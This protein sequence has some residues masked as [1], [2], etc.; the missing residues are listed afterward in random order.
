M[1]HTYEKISANSRWLPYPKNHFA[2]WAV[3]FLI[4]GTIYASPI[5]SS[6]RIPKMGLQQTVTGTVTDQ[7]NV[8]LPGVTIL[9]KGTTSG[10]VSDIDGKYTIDTASDD[11]LAFSY[12]GFRSIEVPV[13]GQSVIDVTLEEDL[14]NLDEV[15]II[16]YGSVKKSDLT[17]SVSS[18][19]DESFNKGA[20][21][22]VEQLIQGRA[23]GVQITQANAQ[24]G[25]AFSIRI[26]GATSITA[27]NEPLFV[28]DGLPS[29]PQNAINPGDIE[30]IEIL[31]DASATAIYGSRGANGVVLITTKQGKAGKI[32]VDY[33]TYA[34][35][36]EVENRLDLLN[37]QEYISFINGIR[38]DQGEDPQFSP[39]DIAAIG[40]GTD[41]QDAIFRSAFVQ[42][43]QFS[44]SGG[45]E[46][47]K[48]YTSLNYFDQ[49]GVVLSSGI[50]RYTGRVNIS[51]TGDKFNF[52]VNLNTSVVVSD[53]VPLGNGINI[54]AGTIGTALQFDPTLAIFDENGD[55]VQSPNLDLNN[56][57]AL[58]ETIEPRSETDRTFGTLFAEYEFFKGFSAKAN[59]G[60][61]RRNIRSDFYA[62]PVTK[63]GQLGNGSASINHAR[64]TSY[65]A[66]LTASYDKTFGEDH[67][68]N[69]LAGI[70][71]QEFNFQGFNAGSQNF[72]TDQFGTDNLGAGDLE[73]Y[74]VGSSR[75]KNQLLSYIGRANYIYKDR[76]LVTATVRADGS[77]RFGED[78][79]YGYFPSVALGWKM[80]NESFLQNATAISNLKLRVS[81]GITGNQ[82]IGNYT[83][84]VLLGTSGDAVFD[85]E[86]FTSIAPSNLANPD[87]RWEETAQFNVGLDFGL[88]N[89]RISGTLDYYTKETSDLL[90]NLPIP[91]TTGFGFTQENVGD[92]SNRGFEVL[93]ETQNIVGDFNWTSTFNFA[94][95]R[96]E[97]TNLGELPFIL[98]G[99]LRFLNDFTIL[100]EGDPLNSYWGYRT[101]GIFQNQE[102]IDASAQPGASPGDLKFADTNED[103]SIDPEDRV[104]LG[105]PFP[106]F[107]LGLNNSF[108]YKGFTLDFFFE[109]V[110]GNELLN[111]TRVDSESPFSLLRNRQSFVQDRWTPDN[112]DSQNP[113]F[114]TSLGGRAVN[115][116]VV[117]DG[118]YIRL[119][120]LRIGYTFPN[121][122]IKG[123]ERLGIFANAQNV[124]T[125]TDYSGF[126]PDVSSFGTSNLRLDY[127]AYPLAR[128]ITLG[129]NIG[130]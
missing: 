71:Y 130:F 83:S 49:E 39:E 24:P 75:N 9:V 129:F 70:S 118:S 14:E 18:L 69:A 66:E 89:N 86:R 117:E 121:G 25:G 42:N 60:V 53:N 72:P 19:S 13:R 4:A 124:F 41:W 80:N 87:L 97:V 10:T 48:F 90:L 30:S 81:Y 61:N 51:H 57:V 15:V 29:Q 79:K 5:A 76:Y 82:E 105:N 21:V 26:R 114:L 101:E 35:F 96:N 91:L 100:R 45:S 85:G 50:Q 94:T 23:A 68:L 27:G 34:G 98:Q 6:P 47:T 1:K 12:I 63:R 38:A 93:L 65:L 116:R 122:S 95:V 112:T 40:A 125:I 20:Q 55:Y 46:K 106:S 11:V 111:F 7:N 22:S 32:R 16:G 115:D 59:F 2:F 77:S 110:F 28:I 74:T 92:T 103:G 108:S 113:S 3:F 84:L 43:H 31:K 88:F 73:T 67:S 8:P 58:A 109:G 119:R 120:N 104:I 127:N 123:I 78:N 64:N 44:V 52:G 107:T 56:P 102:E 17:G 62:A 37:T 36:Q 128:I 99:N 54:G 33:E 126:N